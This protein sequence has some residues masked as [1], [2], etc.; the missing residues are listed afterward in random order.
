VWAAPALA[1]PLSTRATRVFQQYNQ[2]VTEIECALGGKTRHYS[3]LCLQHKHTVVR[4]KL[5][6]H[7][8]SL[9]RSSVKSIIILLVRH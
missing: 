4:L 9:Y 3:R 2:I 1:P 8:W 5:A 6:K 7:V